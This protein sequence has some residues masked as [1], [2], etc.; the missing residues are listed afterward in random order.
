MEI[1]KQRMTAETTEPYV[2]FLIGMRIN[3]LWKMHKWLPVALAMPKMLRELYQNSELGFVHAE[4]WFGRTTIFGK[5]VAV[6]AN[7]DS[8]S[9]RLKNR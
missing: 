5:H 6:S 9:Q 1:H 8:A 7:N 3:K 2:V 4:Q